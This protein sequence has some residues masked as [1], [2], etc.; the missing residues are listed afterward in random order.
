VIS[1]D[2]VLRY[3]AVPN[4]SRK[5][6]REI[7]AE[8]E[9]ATILESSVQRLDNR[10]KITSILYDARTSRRLWGGA[11][12]REINDLFAIQNDVAQHIAAAL[13]VRLSA[14]ERASLEL[15]PTENLTAYDLYLR[16]LAFFELRHQDDNES[17]IALFRQALEEDPK[18]ALGYAGLANAYIE[19][20]ARYEGEAFWLD[21]AID[22]CQK[23]IALDPKQVRGY[24]VL[25]RAFDWKELNDQAREATRKAL[26]LAP[27][28]VEANKRAAYQLSET[29]RFEEQYALLRKC[30]TLSPND[31]YEPYA[32]G[33][34]CAV[35]ED[36]DLAE[37]W[38]ERSIDLEEDP[39]RRRMMEC[40]R[41]IFRRDFAGA[42]IGL[43]QLPLELSTYDYTVLELYAGCSARTGDW[44]TVRRLASARLEKGAGTW[45]W[46][47]WALY[48]LALASRASGQEAEAR[49]TAERVVASVRESLARGGTHFW[50]QYSLAVEYRFLG[51]KE[52]AYQHLRSVFPAI[53]RALPLMRDDPAVSLFAPD[54]EFQIIIS[55]FEEKNKVTRA[56]I[57]EI[58]KR[59]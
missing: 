38:M 44:L 36:K 9:V 18:F 8:L 52:E 42:L 46:D 37:S 53:L 48:Y 30:H 13:Q 5:T 23:A 40:E 16:G 41:M 33:K 1:H 57:H 27:N 2:S 39:Q 10:V 32:L 19:R 35:I 51:R 49:E 21:S 59:F 54:P 25:A 7:G 31:P 58:E 3:K 55:D 6:L 11:Y 24:T 22:L 28:D 47:K 50:A 15:Q 56:K 17:A 26:E 12:D 45:D 43:R 34:I 29:D 20:I 4:T 14:G